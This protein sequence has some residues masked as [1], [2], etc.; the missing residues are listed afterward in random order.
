MSNGRIS[1]ISRRDF[2]R[3]ELRYTSAVVPAF[4]EYVELPVLADA[5]MQAADD[6]ACYG[7]RRGGVAYPDEQNPNGS[8][9]R[10]MW[11][12]G[13]RAVERTV[14]FHLRSSYM[15]AFEN[16]L[17]VHFRVACPAHIFNINDRYAGSDEEGKA[18]AV[19]NLRELAMK[20][21]GADARMLVAGPAIVSTE[22]P[23]I[24]CTVDA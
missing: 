15:A 11:I 20:L 12:A 23:A 16:A 21:H 6:V 13:L 1:S 5:V 8:F 14:P 4:M 2:W 18:W 7:W 9:P 22:S 17:L 3:T 24:G 10:C 19:A